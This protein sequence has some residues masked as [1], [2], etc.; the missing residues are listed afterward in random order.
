MEGLFGGGGCLGGGET[1]CFA[2]LWDR[3]RHQQ[4][5]FLTVGLVVLAKSIELR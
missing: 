1:A 3:L 2:S 4:A 5:D